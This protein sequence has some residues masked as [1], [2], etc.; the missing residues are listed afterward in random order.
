MIKIYTYISKQFLKPLVFISFA[1]G[2]I[3]M[4]SEFFRE[5]S[6]YME[7]KTPFFTVMEYLLLNLPWWI[8][9]VFAVSVLLA[10]L[11]SLGELAKRNEIIALKASGVN[12][13]RIISIFMILGFCVGLF[14]F[15]MREFVIP[16]TIVKAQYVRKVKIKKNISEK[17]PKEHRNIIITLPQNSR[18]SVGYLNIENGYMRDIIIDEYND[19]YHLTKNIVVG[20]GFYKNGVWLLKN[21]VIRKF[22]NN[23]N[24]NEQYFESKIFDFSVKPE[25]LVVKSTRCEQMTLKTFKKYI[26]KRQMLGENTLEDEIEYN[27]RFANVFCHIIVMMI[28]IPF[29]LGLGRKFGKIISFTFA[30]IFSF[31]YWAIQDV[32]ISLGKNQVIDVLLAA[33]LPTVLFAVVGIY[34]M[35]KIKK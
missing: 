6:M 18:M 16:H 17:F 5:M 23:K 12:L 13:W 29:A 3:V 15:S 1:F 10:L 27:L 8:I 33:W 34:L 9:Q 26:Q 22:D 32:S 20:E 28:G 21:G 11:F 30:L 7:L 25:D 35:S 31:I 2:F 14:D 4:I 24:W 19:K